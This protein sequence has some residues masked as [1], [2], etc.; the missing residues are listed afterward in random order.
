[1]R[2][3]W[4]R[5]CAEHA[6][7]QDTYGVGD[8]TDPDAD[9]P[10]PRDDDCRGRDDCRTADHYR[11]A[12]A[13]DAAAADDHGRAS[14]DDLGRDDDGCSAVTDD[15]GCSAATDDGGG[16]TGFVDEHAVGLDRPRPR[17]RRRRRARDRALEPETVPGLVVE[18]ED[19]RSPPPDADRAGRRARARLG[20]HRPS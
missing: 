6:H 7:G 2:R 20:R 15:D 1:M 14:A 19:R 11:C 13:D 9:Y 17:T 4:R 18:L 16:G 5:D 10:C 3:R 8:V 12:A